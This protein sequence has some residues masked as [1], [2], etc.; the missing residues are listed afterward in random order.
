MQV[1]RSNTIPDRKY[2]LGD[3]LLLR[4]TSAKE[5]GVIIDNELNCNTHVGIIT[6]SAYVRAYLIHT[7]FISGNTQSLARR[8][9]IYVRHILKYA[10]STWPS[11]T[12]TNIKSLN[13]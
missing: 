1:C 7:C 4:L 9:V 3:R 2:T 8:F 10:S 12:I 11:S 13:R 5:L 6:G